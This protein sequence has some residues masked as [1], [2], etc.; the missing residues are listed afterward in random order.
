M[1]GCLAAACGCVGVSGSAKQAN[2]A[3][4]GHG[5]EANAA[6]TLRRSLEFYRALPAFS[7]DYQLEV[8]VKKGDFSGGTA[9]CFCV[10][11]QQPNRLAIREHAGANPV[12][13]LCDGSRVFRF[14]E[15]LNRYESMPA[16]E[17]VAEIDGRP[18]YNQIE[19]LDP[20]E[21]IKPLFDGGR[22]GVLAGAAPIGEWTGTETLDG[23]SCSHIR[24]EAKG[25]AWQVWV[26]E[27]ARPIVH[28]LE[29]DLCVSDAVSVNSDSE[30][31][32][33]TIEVVAHYRNW[34]LNP[35]LSAETFKFTPPAD[36]EVA[37]SLQQDEPGSK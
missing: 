15:A 32:G 2:A 18:S 11:M 22:T 19:H 29:C 16:P 26:E 4:G 14:V 24:F 33:A 20:L 35:V 10:A 37:A 25:C 28:K 12:L 23:F 5:S 21:F 9:D 17:S 36:V 27:G 6:K 7:M 30:L 31:S 8:R 3:S 34:A 1:A 13:V